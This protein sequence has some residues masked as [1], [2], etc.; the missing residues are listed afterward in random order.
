MLMLAFR[1]AHHWAI[2]AAKL[3]K[4]HRYR[5]IRGLGMADRIADV[6][7]ER[8]HGE[9]QLIGVVRIAEE[10]HDKI[11]GADVVGQVGIEAV[12]KGVVAHI[13]YHAAT[14]S[15]GAGLLKLQRSQVGIAAEQQGYDRVLPGEVDELLVGDNG[16]SGRMLAAK[17][18]EQKQRDEAQ[19]SQ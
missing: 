18:H 3:G 7:G 6:V 2:A 11:A 15:V 9:G 8:A 4:F 14:V 17:Q 19:K 5:E 13:L 16:V 1:V 12:A 10:A